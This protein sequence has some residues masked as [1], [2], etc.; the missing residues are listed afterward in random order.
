MTTDTALGVTKKVV[1]DSGTSVEQDKGAQMGMEVS[2]MT[3]R[4]RLGKFHLQHAGA[5]QRISWMEETGCE[6]YFVG[7]QTNLYGK[8]GSR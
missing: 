4:D 8:G 6:S 5:Q 3:K 2:R 1:D 7:M